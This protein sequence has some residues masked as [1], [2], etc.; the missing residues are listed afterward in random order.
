MALLR[1]HPLALSLF[2][3][4][5]TAHASDTTLGNVNVTAKGYAAADLESPVS[6]TTLDRSEIVRRGA[7]NVG[8]ALRGE[9]GL[10]VASD[11]AQGQ[12]PVIRGMQKESVVLL[13]DGMRLE[14][15]QPAGAVA[16]FMSLG[17]AEQLEVVKGPASVLYGTGA[18]GGVINV[19]L[20]QAKFAAGVSF[21][22]S[23]GFDSASRGLRG[24][25]VMNAS[26]GDHALMLGLSGA[27]IGDYD[28]PNSRV[29][30]TGYDSESVIGQ[31]RFRIDNAQQLR[32]SLQQHSDKDVWYPGSTKSHASPVV[33]SAT[34][35]SPEQTRRLA[36]V[37][38]SRK[39]SGEAPLNIDAR[40][41]QQEMERTISSWA[42]S[43]GRDIVTNRVV[44]A[45]NGLDAKA[46]WLAHPQ[47]LLSFG[48]NAWRMSGNPDRMMAAPPAF[49]TFAPN[50]PFKDASIDALGLYVQDDMRFG[51]LNLL[52][53][54]RRDT[55]KGSAASMN[56]GTVTSGLDRSDSATSGSIGAIYE[57]APLLRPYANVSRAFRAPAMRERYES[58]LRGD[59]FYYAGSPQVAPEIAQQFE[60]GVKG[61][62]DTFEY[63]LS[64]YRN[65]ISDY[66]T[67][68]RL[69]GT[70]ATTACGAANAAICKKVVNLGQVTI[71]GL[72]AKARWQVSRGH[73]L[74]AGYSRVRGENKDL[75]EPLFQ[76]PA[77]EISLGWLGAIAPG[78]KAD[79]TLRLVARQER[80]ATVFARG[81]EN[82]TAGFATADLGASW[83]IDKANS[84]RFAVRNLADKAYHEHLAEGVSGS[85]IEAVGRNF[86]MSWKGS[87]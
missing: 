31:Y 52:A 79:A 18:L 32:L 26:S 67:G 24:T 10:A 80:V 41:Y 15:A 51:K 27:R 56:N 76:M 74:S 6:A 81:S 21:D 25:G 48:V 17:F 35:H 49:S 7:S 85:E 43:L 82:Q 8:E 73:W 46:D 72:E 36:E 2:L 39:G 59:G 84:L 54:L 53:G 5:S 44:F 69:S 70:A 65:R 14:S 63:G 78:W 34:V 19:L 57:A 33:G 66:I 29:A 3:A 4:F 9:P 47:H 13:V 61:A 58:G 87:F 38:Y 1:P 62:S 22:L 45:T 60:I 12:N 68:L 64:A 20:P 42:N 71:S 28:A 37:G 77:D 16:S 86:Q 75:N 50:N 55:V 30:R 40:L 23:A 11:S 83:Q